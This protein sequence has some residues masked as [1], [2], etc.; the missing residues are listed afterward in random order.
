MQVDYITHSF[1]TCKSW[2][3]GKDL[4][5]PFKKV[6]KSIN[7]S[8]TMCS[9][10]KGIRIHILHEAW[11]T[12]WSVFTPGFLHICVSSKTQFV[13]KINTTNCT[14]EK[15][16]WN[17]NSLL[18]CHIS[19]LALWQLDVILISGLTMGRGG[20]GGGGEARCF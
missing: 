5:F 6:L 7:E 1:Y 15:Q 14:P 12:V 8:M 11:K 4:D 9:L 18:Y 13:V 17:S 19:I 20:G 10:F 3:L 2:K 16:A